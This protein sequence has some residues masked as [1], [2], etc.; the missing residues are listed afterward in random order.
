MA[1][2]V[3]LDISTTPSAPSRLDIGGRSAMFKQLQRQRHSGLRMSP[4]TL[5]A[6]MHVTDESHA[7]QG[8][9]CSKFLRAAHRMGFAPTTLR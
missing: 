4:A 8:V 6:D 2:L 5:P 3:S 1:Y 9:V 7:D